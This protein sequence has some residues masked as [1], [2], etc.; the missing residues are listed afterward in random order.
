[1]QANRNAKVAMQHAAPVVD[2]LR[3]KSL[4]QSNLVPQRGAV[5]GAGSVAQH[6][7]DGIAWNQM[8]EEEDQRHHQPYNGQCHSEAGEQLAHRVAFNHNRSCCRSKVTTLPPARTK[9]V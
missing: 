3:A 5:G 1:M 2:I 7:I 4:V 9:G 8:D 6:H